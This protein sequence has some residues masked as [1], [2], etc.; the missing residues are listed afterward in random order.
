MKQLIPFLTL[1]VL[2]PIQAIGAEPLKQ[3]A[4]LV[5]ECYAA[6]GLE[7]SNCLFSTAKHP[8]CEG[9]QL[10]KLV[11]KRWSMSSVRPIGLDAPAFLGPQLINQECVSN[12]D[13]MLVASLLK[14]VIEV[15]VLEKLSVE[16]QSCAHDVSNKLTR[17]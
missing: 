11:Y 1:L 9:S 17:P 7:Q 14:D 16:L 10:G 12:F 5:A 8:F 3:C 2:L 13:N 4:N 6:D 15:A